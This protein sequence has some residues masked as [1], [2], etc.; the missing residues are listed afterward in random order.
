MY[1]EISTYSWLLEALAW[2][3]WVD[4]YFGRYFYKNFLSHL[5]IRNYTDQ[6]LCKSLLGDDSLFFFR[7]R[8]S[9][10][11]WTLIFLF[12]AL[13][14]FVLLSIT[15]SSWQYFFNKDNLEGIWDF[16][17]FSTYAFLLL[18]LLVKKRIYFLAQV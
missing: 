6:I 12:G 9:F 18:S 2:I 1:G 7:C 13:K 4:Y 11:A 10:S 8:F 17:L 5:G 15:I 3:S 16:F 14:T